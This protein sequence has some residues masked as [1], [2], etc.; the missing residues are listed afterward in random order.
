MRRVV[1]TGLGLVTP[2]GIGKQ[3]FWDSLSNG[4]SGVAKL[5]NYDYTDIP[6]CIGAEVKDFKPEEWIDPK[7]LPRTDQFVQFAIA[8][9]QL[10]VQDGSLDWS[11]IDTDRVGT[12]ISTGIGGLQT[13]DKNI[14][15][16]V[17]KGYKRVSP[18]FIPM[19]I[20][21]MASAMVSMKYK[22][23]GPSSNIVTACATSNYAL[24]EAAE[25]IK[26]DDA[27][28]MLAGGV[29]AS[30]IPLGIA[31]FANMRALSTRNDDPEKASRPFDKDRDGF[32]MG[33]GGI[34][35]V[36]EELEH[37]KKRGANIYCEILSVGYSSDAYHITAPDPDGWGGKK[38]MENAIKKAGIKPEQISYIN[39]HGTST[40]L[41]DR[42][43]S[44]AISEL[45]GQHTQNILVNST[46]SMV[47]HLL[48]AAGA[49]EAAAIALQIQNQLV[50]PSLNFV[51]GE[52][53]FNLNIAKTAT[54]HEINYVLSNSFGFGGHNSCLCFG[55]YN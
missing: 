42:I 2:I 51:E 54:K 28:M 8:A 46:K 41:N 10:A 26:R 23:R 33:E 39:A 47:G 34:V 5:K 55:R 16:T 43:E 3:N 18:L 40:P 38:C 17:E 27:D 20:G 37:A 52:E 44:K 13:L 53:G 50:H 35:L 45:F 12:L 32:V 21:N 36:L 49:I 11:K 4:K 1:V 9:A 22:L 29:E 24:G 14:K 25:L 31:G 48:G 6:V 30:L 19:M 15:M 7:E